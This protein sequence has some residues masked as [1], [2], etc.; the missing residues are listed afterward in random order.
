M[1]EIVHLPAIRPAR[2]AE[3]LAFDD[4]AAH[5]RHLREPLRGARVEHLAD[6]VR[7]VLALD[8]AAIARVANLVRGEAD[9]LPFWTFRILADPPTCWLEVT[10]TGRAGGLARAVFEELAR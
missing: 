9:A 10:G 3:R 8:V 1:T 7:L 2:L 4:L 6:G 5:V